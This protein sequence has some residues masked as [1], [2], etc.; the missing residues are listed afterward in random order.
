MRR[1][2]ALLFILAFWAFPFS[3]QAQTEIKLAGL[4]VQ[5]WPEYDQPSMLVIYDFTLPDT[6]TLPANVAIRFPANANLIAVA[7]GSAPSFLNAS[8]EGPTAS[9]D[10]QT[11]TIKVETKANYHIEYYEPISKTDTVRQFAYLWPGDYAIDDFSISIRVP[12]DTINI[13]TDPIL[14]SSQTA[15]GTTFLVKDFGPLAA[16]QQFTLSLS[17]TRTSDQ[18]GASQSSVQPSEPLSSSTPGRVIWSNYIPYF[19]GGAGGL[20]IIG[21][22]V[23]LFLQSNRGGKSQRRNRHAPRSEEEP[24]SE[25]YCHQ[26]GTRAHAGD[27]FCRVCG[28]KLRT[29]A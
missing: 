13:T 29:S 12:L 28:V 5:L 26:C 27:R 8:Y 22:L 3:A 19:L 24:N 7:S 15:D 21:G 25:I 10:W 9:G 6:T 23:Y 16:A 2:L 4:Q 11:V 1:W 20:L 17:Y 18:L 14:Q